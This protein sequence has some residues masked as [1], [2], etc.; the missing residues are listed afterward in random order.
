MEMIISIEN[1]ATKNDADQLKQPAQEFT[2]SYLS[3]I[4]ER[5]IKLSTVHD[6]NLELYTNLYTEKNKLMQK[7]DI[8]E[9]KSMQHPS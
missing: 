3:M 9:G 5:L 4:K 6:T 2:K 8:F 7:I 1:W